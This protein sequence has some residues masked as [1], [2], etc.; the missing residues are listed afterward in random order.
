[1]ISTKLNT[2]LKGT[3]NLSYQSR[4]LCLAQMAKLENLHL[5]MKHAKEKNSAL[6]KSL[7]QLQSEPVHDYIFRN[8]IRNLYIVF[9]QM[10][11]KSVSLFSL[12]LQN[13]NTFNFSAK[14]YTTL[15]HFK[16]K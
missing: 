12:K 1:M 3:T 2:Q 16:F 7:I 10:E 8:S 9:N 6:K 15:N 4:V 13:E 11:N 14:T 5:N